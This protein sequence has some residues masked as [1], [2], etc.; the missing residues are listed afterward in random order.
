[1]KEETLKRGMTFIMF[2]GLTLVIIAIC[3]AMFAD[4]H[5]SMG[6]KG[7]QIIATIAGGGLILLSPAKLFLTLLLMKND[8]NDGK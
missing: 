7:I 4:L 5:I 3:L 2:L 1:M 6:M 8:G